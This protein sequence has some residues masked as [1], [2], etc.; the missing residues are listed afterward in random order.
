[1]KACYNLIYETDG[2]HATLEPTIQGDDKHHPSGENA[3][4]S[5]Q[6]KKTNEQKAL[7]RH[8]SSPVPVNNS[9][10]E[11]GCGGKGPF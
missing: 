3:L 4:F 10:E 2:H 1:M 5:K 9:T 11:D 7:S 6:T 8:I